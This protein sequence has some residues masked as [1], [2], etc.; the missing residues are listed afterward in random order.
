MYCTVRGTTDNPSYPWCPES[1][2]DDYFYCQDVANGV[3]P[4]DSEDET[5]RID[6]A[7]EITGDVV[8]TLERIEE[9][10]Q[11]HVAAALA[12]CNGGAIRIHSTI[13]NIVFSV[14]EDHESGR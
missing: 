9:F 2:G 10:L 4:T 5:Y 14:Q 3:G 8:D 6:F 13:D 1:F 7:L 12:G 11:T